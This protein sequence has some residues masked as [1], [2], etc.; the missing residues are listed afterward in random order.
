MRLQRR[1]ATA[2][3]H[4][5]AGAILPPWERVA[6]QTRATQ[7]ADNV[8]DPDRSALMSYRIG[9]WTISPLPGWLDITDTVEDDDPAFTLAKEDGVGAL[10]FSS[11]EYE[12]GERPAPTPADLA[13]MVREFGESHDLGPPL[14]C[15]PAPG[16]SPAGASANFHVDEDLVRVWYLAEGGHFLL[17]TYM[18][19]QADRGL[20]LDEAEAIVR[21]VRLTA[22][23]RQT[24]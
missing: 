8:T 19:E 14:D 23:R 13:E 17:V 15:R 9:P 12:S 20:E 3:R 24:A 11:A 5:G 21:G 16:T 6:S 2:E 10:Q 4:G 7:S 22:G 1:G 18:C